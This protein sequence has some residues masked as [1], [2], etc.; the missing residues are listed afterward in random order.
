[1]KFKKLSKS[2]KRKISQFNK[3]MGCLFFA[4]LMM[5]SL[6]TPAFAAVNVDGQG[7]S[8]ANVSGGGANTY[9]ASDQMWKISIYYSRY[10]TNRENTKTLGTASHWKQYGKTF[11]MYNP[12]AVRGASGKIKLHFFENALF[13]NGNKAQFLAQTT[14]ITKVNVGV[15]YY[16][17]N[18]FYSNT[19]SPAIAMDGFTIDAVKEF[20][21]EDSNF[22]ALAKEAYKAAGYDN[23]TNPFGNTTFNI[24]GMNGNYV[25]KTANGGKSATTGYAWS[26][27]TKHLT[28][29]DWYK[30]I[31]TDYNGK[32]IYL[33]PK[34]SDG[35]FL[36]ATTWMI[37]YEPVLCV[38]VGGFN[39]GGSTYKYV[40]C[41]PTEF[42]ILQQNGVANFYGLG[43]TIFNYLS[44]STYLD[45][46]WVGI[47]ARSSAFTKNTA[48]NTIYQQAGIGMTIFDP[49]NYVIKDYKVDISAPASVAVGV[50][51]N[52]TFT[53]SNISQEWIG[54]TGEHE[55][56]I[57]VKYV[58]LAG[59]KKGSTVYWFDL[60]N[61][62]GKT[63]S[64][65]TALKNSDGKFVTTYADAAK[66]IESR[67]ANESNGLSPF[68]KNKHY[69]RGAKD[70]NGNTR[71]KS[72]HTYSYT[73]SSEFNGCNLDLRISTN[74]DSNG[75][76]TNAKKELSSG[77]YY[78]SGENANWGNNFIK[79]T[80]D[81]STGYIIPIGTIPE[82]EPVIS[83]QLNN[84]TSNE[85]INLAGKRFA[86]WCIG[87]SQ[88]SKEE[89]V[90]RKYELMP[91]TNTSNSGWVGIITTDANGYGQINLA[92]ANV[93]SGQDIYGTSNTTTNRTATGVSHGY[94]GSDFANQ[95]AGW[96][97]GGQNK[98]GEAYFLK[99][100]YW[101]GNVVLFEHPAHGGV[102]SSIYSL[103][104][105]VVTN[106]STGKVV[107]GFTPSYQIQAAKASGYSENSLPLRV[108][109]WHDQYLTQNG[110]LAQMYGVMFGGG[111]N[112]GGNDGKSNYYYHSSNK[113]TF[114]IR[115]IDDSYNSTT[116]Y[117]YGGKELKVYGY[118][119]EN[120]VA[121]TTQA[122]IITFSKIKAVYDSSLT[123]TTVVKPQ[124][125]N[126]F[127]N[128]EIA[129]CPIKNGILTLDG[130]KV[131]YEDLI[132][133]NLTPS[134]TEQNVTV[135]IVE[136]PGTVV[137]N[138]AKGSGCTISSFQGAQVS[139][140][141]SS[142]N[143]HNGTL[144]ASGSV[145][146]TNI[147]A[148]PY[149][150]HPVVKGDSNCDGNL[151]SCDGSVTQLNTAIDVGC[152]G[153]KIQI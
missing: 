124:T 97:P 107:T 100:D 89:G 72:V 96:M 150:V 58:W 95:G 59:I 111:N 134:N 34:T 43:S 99:N 152:N 143:I 74:V 1:M 10:D 66:I 45:E 151:C 149:T 8:S 116:K 5:L 38:E 125:T 118:V 102:D 94:F 61:L 44:N 153:S 87:G 63:L 73:V 110:T 88:A 30:G 136:E 32:Q 133:F 42:A 108:L 98:N 85:D 130:S 35:T 3:K 93:G 64:T 104:N 57:N 15:N 80:A 70:S 56:P 65:S 105:G 71:D 117:N 148:G 135:D 21:K 28:F 18:H 123:G 101:K 83:V 132:V 92:D 137:V 119:N 112:G 20:F 91:C 121:V 36:S 17:D 109:G 60:W 131:V 67:R 51:F 82:V 75:L 4:L 12:T 39:I 48:L 106:K 41:T 25:D 9:N 86:V 90:A 7:G 37:V 103:S 24:D 78:K 129:N 138:Y 126:Y 139:L 84:K 23:W 53:H 31:K 69:Y 33:H 54:N 50:P 120:G 55:A 6:A 49:Y 81:S 22:V 142:G 14:D 145:T 11:Y 114:I 77:A 147:P 128:T 26:T 62:R 52:I 140:H 146:F 40:A 144:N 19:S 115:P 79:N 68:N 16:K 47:S 2:K 29:N 76:Y 141:D 127:L 13:V 113:M 46:K 27:A 122:N